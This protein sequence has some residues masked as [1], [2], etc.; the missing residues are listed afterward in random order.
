[1]NKLISNINL[2]ELEL[3]HILAEV[4]CLTNFDF[5]LYQKGFI[6]RRT[7]FFMFKNN[8]LTESDLIYRINNSSNFIGLFLET[9]F[10]QRFELFRDADLWNYI[11]EK[12]IPKLI[13]KDEVK[14]H[15]PYATG[16][17]ELYSFLYILNKFDTKNFNIYITGVTDKHL[18]IIKKHI[19]L[20]SHIK[21]SEKNIGLLNSAT[22]KDDIFI[23]RN[24][25]Y[26]IKNNF[27]GD[28]NY[29]TCNFF[30]QQNLAEFDLVFF[31][32]KL[33]FFNYE[34]KT[35]AL[36]NIVRSLKKGGYIVLGEKEKID[37]ESEKKI[38]KLHKEISIYKRK[39]F[40]LS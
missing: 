32:N 4:K 19:F 21:F 16:A 30:K 8:I 33:I 35:K 40:S 38:K 15:F 37:N 20:N 5:S 34:L 25:Y 31:Q 36:N 39:T 14:I 17:E 23:E 13:K 27:S 10:F 26:I 18:S 11:E 1:M 28:I 7:E 3:K 22:D 29:T 2:S 24:N 12:I 9:I 6:K